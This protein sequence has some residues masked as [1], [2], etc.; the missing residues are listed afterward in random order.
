MGKMRSVVQKV[1]KL[2]SSLPLRWLLIGS[3][4]I[5]LAGIFHVFSSMPLVKL[6]TIKDVDGRVYP[7]KE[8]GGHAPKGIRGGITEYTFSMENRF[9]S[10]RQLR[11]IPDDYLLDLEINGIRYPL[12]RVPGSKRMDYVHGLVLDLS[13]YLVDGPNTIHAKISNAGGAT[14]LKIQ[15]ARND[16][17]GVLALVVLGIGLCGL[18]FTVGRWRDWSMGLVM[19]F[20]VGIVLRMWALNATQIDVRTYD[21]DGHIEYV[22][23]VINEHA[24]PESN[25]GWQF[26]QPGLYYMTSALWTLPAR[27]VYPG[28][29]EVFTRSLQTLSVILSVL[30]LALGLE[31]LRYFWTHLKNAPMLRHGVFARG[32]LRPSLGYVPIQG[33]PWWGLLVS[34]LM[35]ATWPGVVIHSVRVG[36]DLLLYALMAGSML[37]GLRWWREHDSRCFFVALLL[38]TLGLWTKTNAIVLFGLFG[39]LLAARLYMRGWRCVYKQTMMYLGVSAV[40]GLLVF[41]PAILKN[42]EGHSTNLFVGNVG[43]LNKGLLVGNNAQNYLF[44]DHR[45][46][47]TEAYASPWGDKGGRQYF[48]NYFLKTSLTG[49]FSYSR[50]V[51]SDL[52][53]L[54][55]W[56]L[57]AILAIGA[58]VVW[59]EVLACPEM[60][61]LALLAFLM[62]AAALWNR[63]SFPYSCSNDFRYS[64]PMVIP[65]IA[66]FSRSLW[67]LRH[68][69][70]KISLFACGLL[71]VLFA[72]LGSWFI[73]A[74]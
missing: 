52:A 47:F 13:G 61:F 55:G 67:L 26:Y 28:F 9:L 71:A 36:N 1:G 73:F 6:Q 33:I 56:L 34:G 30:F 8:K 5:T 53:I 35:L 63:I 2:Y 57:L 20:V 24:L 11:F 39:I 4:V 43:S 51:S 18:A 54:L 65:M 41:G 12:Q 60:Q 69:G 64:L 14:G 27:L 44:F 15:P 17:S 19:V 29:H 49:E 32:A 50:Q 38:A 59:K 45:D 23:H 58:W 22:Q 68:K 40:A 46:Y 72:V 31:M 62:L 16:A 37:F 74:L 70:R 25:K 10:A 42:L 21:V 66:F 48:V 7:W 3:V